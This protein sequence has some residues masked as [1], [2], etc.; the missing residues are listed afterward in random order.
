MSEHESE[1][2]SYVD[3]GLL[4][5]QITKD[6]L[7]KYP[8]KEGVN[9]RALVV[10]QDEVLSPEVNFGKS[11]E[12]GVQAPITPVVEKDNLSPEMNQRQMAPSYASVVLGASGK[13]GHRIWLLLSWR[14]PWKLRLRAIRHTLFS[15][16]FLVRG[17]MVVMW[18]RW[19]GRLFLLWRLFA[20]AYAIR[21]GRW[22]ILWNRPRLLLRRGTLKVM[23]NPSLVIP[24]LFFLIMRLCLELL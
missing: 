11:K 7:S 2:D 9:D 19:L 24:L 13:C 18:N 3:S 6:S 16:L 22:W 15:L 12:G 4:I 14:T 23:L 10:L 8:D 17:R 21:L 20:A 5:D 1:E